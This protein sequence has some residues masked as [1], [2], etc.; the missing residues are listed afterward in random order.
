MSVCMILLFAF[1]AVLVA[2]ICWLQIVCGAE[3]TQRADSQTEMDRKLQSPRGMILDRNGK[4]LAISEMAKSLYADPTMLNKSPEE[5]AALLAPYV[6]TPQDKVV[7]KLKRDTAFVWLDRI[8]ETDK[9]DAVRS[10]IDSEK[11]QGLRFIEENH[12]Y[13]PNNKLAAQLLGFVGDNDCGLDGMELVLDSEIRGDIQSLRLTTDKNAVPLFD[14]ALEKILPDKKR[15]VRLTIDETLQ[16]AAEQQLDAI[17]TANHPTGAAIIIMDPRTGEILAMGSR[18][19][20]NPNEYGKGNA[21]QYKNRAVNNLYEP[22]STF[23]PI[24][25]ASA[26]DSGKWKLNQTYLDQGYV[27]IADRTI[28]NWDKEGRGNVTLRDILMYSIN[29][30]MAHIGVTTGAETLTEYARRFGFG[31]PTGIELPGEGDGILFDVEQMSR[32]DEAIMGIGQG[33]AVTPLQMV[34][35]FG[36]IANKGHMM[37]PFLIQE[38]DNADGSVYKKTEPQEVGQPVSEE[39]AAAIS[40]ILADEVS[41][42]G[43]QN[44]H[45]EGYRFAGK[46]GTAQRLNAFGTGYA[47]GQYIAS[48]VGFGPLEDPQYV[49]LIVIDNPSGMYYGAQIAAPVFKSLMTDIVRMKGLE[50]AHQAA[51][52]KDNHAEEKIPEPAYTIPPVQ[53]TDSGVLLPSFAGWNSREVNDWLMKAQLGFVPKGTGRAVSQYPEPGSYVPEGTDVTVQFLR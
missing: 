22:G 12:R 38:I 19:T 1:G 42:G 15:T 33:I 20:F 5:I 34:Q 40:R 3:L 9:A 48:F 7:E 50:P 4:V 16:F 31:R 46:T 8:M 30:G 39:T 53:H 17:M 27:D 29:T 35:A 13:Y 11:L 52:N 25:A 43:G 45:V 24:V 44:A 32:I 37:K 18:P 23:K 47:E 21:E 2:R 6:R 14:S 41:S 49:V 51:E 28:Y 10:I 36:A 26:L